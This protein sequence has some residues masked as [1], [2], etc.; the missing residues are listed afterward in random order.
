MAPAAPTLATVTAAARPP[1][2]SAATISRR[3]VRP[4]NV[5]SSRYFQHSAQSAT[6]GDGGAASAASTAG[7][8][9]R[10]RGVTDPDLD[11][12]ARTTMIV[13]RTMNDVTRRKRNV[14]VS[15]MIEDDRYDDRLSFLQLCETWL[16]FK[17][18]L[19]E[20][21]CVRLGQPQPGRPRRLLV[22]TGSEEIAA[23]LIHDAPLF[24]VALDEYVKYNIFINPD[25]SPAAAKLAFER[26][27]ARRSARQQELRER[28][29]Y[30]LELE[31]DEDSPRRLDYTARQGRLAGIGPD[32]VADQPSS[33]C[34]P[35]A[36]PAV[37]TAAGSSTT[38]QADAAIQAASVQLPAATANISAVNAA[39][40]TTVSGLLPV[41]AVPAGISQ[42]Q[43][44]PTATA[45]P[46][47]GTG[48]AGSSA[49][50]Q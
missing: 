2:R 49:P 4:K 37:A 42:Q 41:A 30:D 10:R 29:E 18:A 47:S 25:L 3:V 15:G 13:H 43:G 35:Q 27:Q 5:S 7:G 1:R 26:R 17:P 31:E 32:T 48:S 20:G 40:T 44:P 45:M 8:Q 16:T 34:S 33:G 19:A 38:V 11:A 6:G 36:A 14:I 50:R 21:S 24:A 46:G 9:D 12:D 23:A 22:R 28:S 39:A